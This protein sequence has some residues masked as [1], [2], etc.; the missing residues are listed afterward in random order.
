[1]SFHAHGVIKAAWIGVAQRG[2]GFVMEDAHLQRS[3]GAAVERAQSHPAGD[4]AAAIRLRGASGALEHQHRA[5]GVVDPATGN[6]MAVPPLVVPGAANEALV[7]RLHAEC[8]QL[9]DAQRTA[10]EEAHFRH[11]AAASSDLP[12]S[13]AE[14]ERRTLSSLEPVKWCSNHLFGP[15]GKCAFTLMVLKVSPG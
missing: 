2:F 7:L 13:D 8:N 5:L 11:V 9:A 10:R 4:R 14:W 6:V 15:G 12:L 1:V 3:M